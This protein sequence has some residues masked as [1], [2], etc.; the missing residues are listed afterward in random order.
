[1]GRNVATFDLG[2]TLVRRIK[3]TSIVSTDQSQ[4]LTGP[5]EFNR[6]GSRKNYVIQ[7]FGQENVRIGYRRVN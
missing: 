4:T 7:F 2:P 5:L 3:A 6:D 1:M